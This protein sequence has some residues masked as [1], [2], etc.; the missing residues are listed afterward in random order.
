MYSKDIDKLVILRKTVLHARIILMTFDIT[1]KLVN[2]FSMNALI[3][4]I[5]HIKCNNIR[6][7]IYKL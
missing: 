6:L 7:N 2:L 4:F 3:R 1:A 5:K